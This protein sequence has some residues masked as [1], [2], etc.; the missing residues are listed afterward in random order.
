MKTKVLETKEGV[1]LFFDEEKWMLL[2]KWR[3]EHIRAVV[4][5]VPGFC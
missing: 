1:A 2:E 4:P 5:I 3:V